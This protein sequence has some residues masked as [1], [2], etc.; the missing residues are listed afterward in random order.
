MNNQFYINEININI[1]SIIPLE[2]LPEYGEYKN[3]IKSVTITYSLPFKDIT[4]PSVEDDPNFPSEFTETVRLEYVLKEEDFGEFIDFDNIS[5]ELFYPIA[6]E[7]ANASEEM[8][9]RVSYVR[10]RTGLD[11]EPPPVQNIS[12]PVIYRAFN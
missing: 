8:A 2:V 6:I 7:L 11:I 5:K 4:A 12:T 9:K 10:V 3:Y 1:G